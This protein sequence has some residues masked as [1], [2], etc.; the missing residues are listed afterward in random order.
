MLAVGQGSGS[1]TYPV[2][3]S[4]YPWKVWIFLSPL[5]EKKPFLSIASFSYRSNNVIL[6]ITNSILSNVGNDNS[7]VY[8]KWCYDLIYE[9]GR[10][11]WLRWICTESSEGSRSVVQALRVV[12]L[13]QF[14]AVLE[15]SW[16]RVLMQLEK[17]IHGRLERIEEAM[18]FQ[19]FTGSPQMT[20][21]VSI[22]W[23][24]LVDATQKKHL[25]PMNM[26]SSF[27]LRFY[28]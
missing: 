13:P 3:R 24:Y 9:S 1:S 7:R 17:T 20:A 14:Y 8:R 21:G 5:K 28:A 22:G 25:V 23:I 27:E 18:M 12:R 4:K 11:R 6:N 16:K 15:V 2:W 19:A 10:C 26:A